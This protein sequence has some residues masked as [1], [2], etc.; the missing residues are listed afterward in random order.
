MGEQGDLSHAVALDGGDLAFQ[1]VL[2]STVLLL[3]DHDQSTADNG[4]QGQHKGEKILHDATSLG[5]R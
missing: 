4:K 1:V 2:V 3:K 5:A